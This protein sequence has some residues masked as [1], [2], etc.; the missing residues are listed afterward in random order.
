MTTTPHVYDTTGA[1]AATTPDTMPDPTPD[2]M[3]D[4]MP[5]PARRAAV[6][7]PPLRLAGVDE[8][9]DAAAEPHLVRGID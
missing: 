2:P 6:V 1:D 9:E 3:A 8:D 4:P 5:D 7:I